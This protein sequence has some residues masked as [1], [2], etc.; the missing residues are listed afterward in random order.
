MRMAPT[1]LYPDQ[2]LAALT[3]GEEKNL[4]TAAVVH[5][6]GRGGIYSDAEERGVVIIRG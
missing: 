2:L 1:V 6:G 3:C 4:M 5:C